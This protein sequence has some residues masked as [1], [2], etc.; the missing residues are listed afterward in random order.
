[1]KQAVVNTLA[2]VETDPILSAFQRF[3]ANGQ[4][5]DGEEL[6]AILKA[7]GDILNSFIKDNEANAMRLARFKASVAHDYDVDEDSYVQG[8]V[9]GLAKAYRWAL[10]NRLRRASL[11]AFLTSRYRHLGLTVADLD[12]M[13]AEA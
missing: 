11:D 13:I 7:G 12:R 9:D 10:A 1:M 3:V 5:H 6:D 2:A 8:A 4:P